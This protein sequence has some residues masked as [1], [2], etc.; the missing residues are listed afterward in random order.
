[1]SKASDSPFTIGSHTCKHLR[2]KL[3]W[4]FIQARMFHDKEAA[5]TKPFSFLLIIPIIKVF[6]L[7]V[8]PYM[9][10]TIIRLDF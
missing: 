1:M 3:S 5:T 7:N 2:G 4:F 8:L 9:V 6:L 10:L